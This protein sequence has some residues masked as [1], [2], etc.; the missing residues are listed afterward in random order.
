MT[1]SSTA[2]DDL[3]LFLKKL[4]ILHVREKLATHKIETIQNLVDA[5]KNTEP[6][7]KLGLQAWMY[8]KIKKQLVNDN[9]VLESDLTD[10]DRNRMSQ[11]KNHEIETLREQL[12]AQEK[13]HEYDGKKALDAWERE[14]QE[15]EHEIKNLQA[16]I[17][18]KDKQNSRLK[19]AYDLIVA[20]VR[21][22]WIP[23]MSYEEVDAHLEQEAM[24]LCAKANPVSP[25]TKEN[26][27]PPD[28]K[29]ISALN[30]PYFITRK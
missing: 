14:V 12:R 17:A 25:D 11:Q 5:V 27:V 18:E 30:N 4:Q 3:H 28:T 6:C 9:R 13:E 21:N 2:I 8:Y 15:K 19:M 23:Y 22:K 26:P 16:T 1:Q 24:K 20:V 29:A 10:D 7:E